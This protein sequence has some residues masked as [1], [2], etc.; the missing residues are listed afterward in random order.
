VAPT[1]LALLG[2]P[3]PEDMDGRVLEEMF[4][5]E[6]RS[7]RPKDTIETYDTE[8]WRAGGGPLASEVDAELTRR[9]KS[10]GYLD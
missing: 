1:V 4:T 5:P 3:V 8:G 6:W 7:G 10:L 2:L 9:L